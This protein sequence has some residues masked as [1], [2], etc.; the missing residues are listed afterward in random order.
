MSEEFIETIAEIQ[1]VV[2]AEV[3]A[4]PK[5]KRDPAKLKEYRAAHAARVKAARAQRAERAAKKAAAK[6]AAKA[7]SAPKKRKSKPQAPGAVRRGP[8]GRPEDKRLREGLKTWGRKVAARRKALRL[9]QAQFGAM[10]GICQ[11]HVC[12]IEK[13]TYKPSDELRTRVDKLCGIK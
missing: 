5:G 1:Q 2:E 11:P 9:T 6:A 10:V 4:K 8:Q 12:N 13:G 3:A 7:K